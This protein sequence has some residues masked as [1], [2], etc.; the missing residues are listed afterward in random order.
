MLVLVEKL[1][2][3]QILEYP[4]D[5]LNGIMA[6]PG[7]VYTIKDVETGQPPEGLV[8][9]RKGKI[10]EI[11]VEGDEVARIDDFFTE[12]SDTLFSA[13]GSF[14]P[15]EDMTIPSS[16]EA[17]VAAEAT[18]AA[19][20]VEHV[21]WQAGSQA[22]QSA[23]IAAGAAGAS[24]AAGVG[25]AAAV[26]SG[27]AAAASSSY[28]VT[29]SAAAGI[30]SSVLRVELYDADGNLIVA[31]DHDFSTGDYS[32]EITNGYNGY[33]FAKVIDTN[34][35]A[36]YEDET[37]G[38]LTNLGTTLRAM[39]QTDGESN[40][41]LT[42][43]PLT[44]LAV[45]LA[46]IDETTL[47]TTPM[48]DEDF[49]SN[50]TVGE[51]F[52]VEDITGPVTTVID[53]DYDSGDGVSASEQYGNVLAMLSGVDQQTGGIEETIETIR[54]NI[55]VEDDGD[56]GDDDSDD[57]SVGL[58]QDAVEL[59]QQ[60]VDE[61]SSGT[62]ADLADIQDA[63]I[64]P[65]IVEAAGGGGV[66]GAEKDA[67]VI[68]G[69]SDTEEGDT[70]VINWAGQTYEATVTAD[71]LN[72]E[73]LAEIR[74]P[75]SVIEA[76]GD[77]TDLAVF[78]TINDGENS[79]K[80]YIDVDAIAPT[81]TVSEID[82][83]TDTGTSDS[84]F[85]T[86]TSSQ[87]ITATLSAA[88]ES[89]DVL[90]GS[91][92]GGSNWTDITDK[93][94]GT[95]VSWDGA[96]I[97]GNNS[98]QF[99]VA[100]KAGNEGNVTSQSY[101]LDTTAPT[102][103]ISGIDI[104]NDSGTSDSDFDTNVSSQTITAT[105]SAALASD[106]ILYGSVD[107]GSTWTDITD[108]VSGTTITWDSATISGSSSIQFKVTDNAGN[109]GPVA[110]QSYVLDETAPTTT[111]SN[112][113][114]SNDTGSSDSDFE[115]NAA[116]Q[117]ITATLSAGLASGEI[118]YGSVDGGSN[119]TDITNKVS[120]TAISWDNVTLAGSNSIMLK[121]VDNAA[122][123]G[124]VAL[125]SFVID[126]TAPTTTISGIDISTDTGTSDGDFETNT[127]SQTITATLSAGLASGETLYGSVDGGSTWTD[128]TDKVSGTAISWDGAT[129]SG[130]SAI[131]F[132]VTDTAG[133]DGSV[134]SQNYVLDETAPTTTISGIDISTDTGSSDSDFET[135][136]AS[137]TITATLSAELASGETLYGSVDGGSNWTDI[138]DKASGT[139][140]NWDNVTLAGS[141]SILIKVTDVAG[142]GGAVA[143]QSF[144]VDTTAPGTTISAIDISSDTGTDDTDFTTN[145]ASQTITATLS[146]A[147][148]TGETLY[149][150]VDGGTNWTDISDKVS[151]T[152][153]SWNGAT[154][155]GSSSIQFKVTDTAGNDGATVS[156]SY[157]L[158]T[159][160]PVI[161]NVTIPDTAMKVGDTVTATLTVDDDGGDAYTNL[162]GTIGGFSLS[163]LTRVS[164]T[165]YTAQFTITHGGTDVAAGSDI[166]VDVTIDDIAGNTST[167][168]A[169]AISQGSD[170]I[171]ANGPVV[172]GV[173][174]ANSSM[175][176]GDTVQVVITVDDDGGVAHTGISGTVG[177]FSLTNLARTDS[178]TYTAEF[179]VTDGGTD[180]AASSD[181][182]VDITM[183]DSNGSTGNNYTTA[184]SQAGDPIDANAPVISN[185]SIPNT[186]MNIGDTVTVTITVSDDGGDTYTNLSGTVGGFSLGS[187]SRVDNTTYE[188]QFTVTQGGTDVA[189]GSDIPVSL[190]LDDSA[191]NTSNTYNTAISQ[192]S[193]AID[194][195]KPVISGVTIPDTVMKAGDTVTVTISVAD[196]GGDTYTGLSGTVAGYS[197][198]NFSR[199]DS[200]T[201]TAEFTITEGDS[202][203]A[204][205]SD[206]AVNITIQ[207]SA[208]NTS[209]AY[210]TAISQTNDR[211]DA[212]SPNVTGASI[213]NTAMAVNDT[214]TVTI[215]VDSDTDT[216]TNISGT[217]GGFALSNLTKTNDTT[218]T[219][220]FT[221]TD[222]G[223]DLAT[224]DAVPVSFTLEDSAG[225]TS[226]T[227]N[228]DI[229]QNNDAIDANRPTLASTSP[230]DNA[231]D[232]G[233]NDDLTLSFSEAVFKGA[234]GN[235]TIKLTSDDSTFEQIA[236]TDAK[237]TGWGGTTLTVDPAGTF[238]D[239][240]GYYV[241]FD[242]NAILDANGS[243]AAELSDKT[244]WNFSTPDNTAPLVSSFTSTTSDGSYK[245]N[246]TINIT[247]TMNEDIQSGGQ[248]T[249]TLNTG[250]TV[251][252]TAS[253]NGTTLTGTYTVQAGN[254]IGDLAVSSFTTG[255]VK[256]LAGNALAD[257]SLPATNI[258]DG[259]DIAIDT[260]APNVTS[261]G[262]ASAIDEN[263]GASQVIYTATS[264]ET[265]TFSLK[266]G[267][268]DE[269]L[270][271]IN[272]SS[273]EVTLT[274]DPDH[275]S[276]SNYSFTVVATDTAGNTGE[277]AVTLSI[278][279]VDE[280]DPSITSGA[281]ASAIDENSGSGQVI[282]TVTATDTADTDDTSDA[283]GS[284]T[285]SLKSGVGDESLLSINS[286]TGAV[287]LTGD[288]DHESKSSYSFTVV[289]TDTGGN[290]DEQAVSLSINDL[291]ETDPSI[292]SGATASAIDENS[293]SG[294]V[295]Y[296]V[297]ATDTADTD[298]ATDT[299]GSL[300]YSLKSGVGDEALFSINS[301]TGAVT[302]T[303]NPD[304]ENKSS[305]SFT[306]VA[307]DT[308][309]NTDE[310]A[311]TLSINDLDES[312]P[313]ITSGTT[314]SAIDENSGSGQ[315]IYTVTA[316]DSA[317]TDDAT[318]ASGSLTYSLKSGVGDESLLSINSS[319][320]AVTLTGDPDHE[321]KSSYSFT[322]VATDTGGNTDEQA[323]TLSINDVDESDPSITS[324][325]TASAI[326]ENSGSGQVIY[327]VTATDTADSDDASDASGSLT[328]SLKSGVGDESL[329]SINSST[330]A[331]TLTGNPDH[332]SKS[333]YSF[334]VVATDTGG[335]TDEQAVTLSINDIDDS[336]PS[337]TSGA[338]ASAID[339][340]SGSGQVIYTVTATDT[341]DSD[342]A[343]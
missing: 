13:D 111:I 232:V 299:S 245:E 165:E 310:Q 181:I 119:W 56:S 162:S 154:L 190:T 44:E 304:H 123:G 241:V 338:T 212:N 216:Y 116:S 302:L 225:N 37:T 286:S 103:T 249:V 158:D 113:D 107:G 202:D 332:E 291:D 100:D 279:D 109:D 187:L 308:A 328:Y 179:T 129:I 42:V 213:P 340:N 142:N 320:G 114:I 199:T 164:S 64:Q 284:L 133:N 314:A 73:G 160:A 98:I 270:F 93:V 297:T 335:N 89:G 236:I 121:V 343:T 322:V 156:Q 152:A 41:N 333:S 263:S 271:S 97:S 293:G 239:S 278:N 24:G 91:V 188:A 84:D 303:G 128:I 32:H 7:A 117:T 258:D 71:I 127:A 86:N 233:A 191:G 207:D 74:V 102:T 292:T 104:S 17:P 108:K 57:E 260:T 287:T 3:N 223:T 131:Q 277:K 311:V 153:V 33:I 272:S 81:T 175:K 200:T 242:D 265:A 285:Y 306:V 96:T 167:N 92:D 82:I 83:S 324:G 195:N 101:V 2:D 60:G 26:G 120:G 319:T 280:S 72:D 6:R 21:V 327:T 259:S 135:N 176:I 95:A 298:D 146:A 248:M 342:D 262:T 336:D 219:A 337:I 309:G 198:S 23:W 67:G 1:K 45:Q 106:D 9:K 235:L 118:L 197:L 305:Y 211:I 325:A 267:V 204:A 143:S 281:T 31:E 218:Y 288:P 168:Y 155:S 87:T 124:T 177:G 339:E 47:A 330:G 247:A 137:Q 39:T 65:P 268:G 35:V 214:V 256:D 230:S 180:V 182:P 27:T 313:S 307:T 132:K 139:A 316:T 253:A 210:T 80:L 11:E 317:D 52:N 134:A 206:H 189:A 69:V 90:Y 209:D 157:I 294:Q 61:F 196:D 215:I 222:G 221:V 315:V 63:I 54:D 115:T 99:K 193:D 53:E 40:V 140:I 38:E 318:D 10:L 172:T 186:P 76:A 251:T 46:G 66:N 282:Y 55:V 130:S 257:T 163:N 264:N 19:D 283:S 112:I 173:S 243:P 238:T 15:P 147:L 88:L 329:L 59:L 220:Q 138:T 183:T 105:L 145:T 326:D 78:Y 110:S 254:T 141:N 51:L 50:D 166:P 151:G 5:Q 205:G 22:G 217:I 246:D 16:L 323:V 252:L 331:V 14:T 18:T 274:G 125:Q 201:Y 170:R 136:T 161:S 290:T 334:T 178:T 203:V 228:T 169:T 34:S 25:V 234:S 12:E 58:N 62:N 192:N 79:P 94:S 148:A 208:G 126:T 237:I 244:V 43:T 231:A 36:D 75:T 8:L 275:E 194:A 28:V 273:G 295:I 144:V 185:V 266:S 341:A 149:G 321:S 20:M 301:S 250:E 300:T 29:L 226:N 68:V 159:T 122:N 224:G 85:E 30:F 49:S 312:D 4:L 240:T 229:T 261:G 77:G 150:S 269:T 296:T 255:T 70:V 289:A 48:T 276:K 171:D 227:Y 174:I 184:I